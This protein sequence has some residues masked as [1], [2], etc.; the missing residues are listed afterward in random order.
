M[1]MQDNKWRNLL[2][3]CSFGKMAQLRE[4]NCRSV[5]PNRVVYGYADDY[6]LGVC[7]WRFGRRVRVWQVDE[8]G[9]TIARA[10][11]DRE[12]GYHHP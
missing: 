9:V 11:V 2:I 10:I 12:N 5:P 8:D 7:D 1:W 4:S 6:A 3:K